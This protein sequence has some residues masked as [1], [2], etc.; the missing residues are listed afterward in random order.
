[1]G[2][3]LGKT[4]DWAKKADLVNAIGTIRYYAGWADKNQGKTI[5]T[6]ET[7]LSY[8]RHEPKGVVGQIIPWNFPRK[9]SSCSSP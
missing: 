3:L 1:M 9:S 8:T 2:I 7:K 5:E 6:T 4:F